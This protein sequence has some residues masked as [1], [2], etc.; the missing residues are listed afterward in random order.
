LIILDMMMPGMDGLETLQRI[1]AL[2]ALAA[3]PA[4]FMTAKAQPNEI[5]RYEHSGAIGVIVKPFD[6]V[7]LASEVKNLWRAA[8]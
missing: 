7:S 3:V 1:R 8:A 2:P 6:P 4:V 5:Q